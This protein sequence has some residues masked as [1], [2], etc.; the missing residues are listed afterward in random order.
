MRNAYIRNRFKRTGPIIR[1]KHSG[2]AGCDYRMAEKL[3]TLKKD[4]HGFYQNK[5]PRSKILDNNPEPM[6][7]GSYF[8]VNI[9][10]KMALAWFLKNKVKPERVNTSLK[11]LF[12]DGVI[13]TGNRR[14]WLQLK[15]RIA[16]DQS[17]PKNFQ[18]AIRKFIS[19]CRTRW[20]TIR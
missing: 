4:W 8:S 7:N 6:L 19:A 16:F 1:E 11:D 17:W 15:H 2:H 20:F 14:C 10:E 3:A 5:L 12:A 13:V 9:N 18:A